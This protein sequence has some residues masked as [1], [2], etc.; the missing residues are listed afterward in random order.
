MVIGI[1]QT[2]D[3][4]ERVQQA[5]GKSPETIKKKSKQRKTRPGRQVARESGIIRE[6]QDSSYK[7]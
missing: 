4:E 5:T 1:L 6:Q 3:R 7:E 2:Q